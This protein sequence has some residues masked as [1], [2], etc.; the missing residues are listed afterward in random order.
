MTMELVMSDS[1]YLFLLSEYT[2][3]DDNKYLESLQN[4]TD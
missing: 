4:D 3:I 1:L 2:R